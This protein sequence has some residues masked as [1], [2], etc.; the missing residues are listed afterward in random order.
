MQLSP[1][2]IIRSKIIKLEIIIV[3]ILTVNHTF[4]PTLSE[5]ALS[6]FA[7]VVKNMNHNIILA[8][9]T[10]PPNLLKNIIM[11]CFAADPPDEI[12]CLGT[13][14]KHLVSIIIYLILSSFVALRYSFMCRVMNSSKIYQPMFV[15]LCHSK[16]VEFFH[17]QQVQCLIYY[18]VYLLTY[19]CY[20]NC[21]VF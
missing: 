3:F 19:Y 11:T 9:K 13:N 4:S 15:F 8:I 17:R 14:L 1:S 10:R 12:V 6:N 21:V 2:E 7:K 16:K 18:C 20:K 5:P